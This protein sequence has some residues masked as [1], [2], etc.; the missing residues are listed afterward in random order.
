MNL[1]IN[2][3]RNEYD[4]ARANFLSYSKATY[5]RLPSRSTGI[6]NR[7][8]YMPQGGDCPA[9]ALRRARWHG[10]PA[11]WAIAPNIKFLEY[12]FV[13]ILMRVGVILKEYEK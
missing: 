12:A 7:T 13:L 2:H 11:G 10:V 4:L 8:K 6:A 1:L 5:G 9:V 3:T